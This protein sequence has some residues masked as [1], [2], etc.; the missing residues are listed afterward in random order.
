MLK[1]LLS[2]LGLGKP[3]EPAAPS[4]KPSSP[5]MHEKLAH[6]QI[7]SKDA[8]VPMM[9]VE[10]MLD[11]M[12]AENPQKLEWRTS[13]VDMM[14]LLDMDSSYESRKA[15]ADELHC[16]SDA[17]E[18]SAKM[19]VWLHKAVMQKVAQNGGKVPQS[20]LD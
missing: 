12:A 2:H 18:D 3:E 1:S 5:I 9:D 4:G 13:I 17:M 19:N 7:V 15:L 6:Y 11:D 8:S 14:K 20:L 10:K 16:P